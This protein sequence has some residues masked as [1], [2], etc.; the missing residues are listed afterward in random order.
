MS[1]ITPEYLLQFREYNLDV[2]NE[3]EKYIDNN[4]KI[5]DL[6]IFWKRDFK[7]K[8]SWFKTKE[9]MTDDEKI[10]TETNDLLN[11]LN[12]SNFDSISD[13]VLKL[14]L[15]CR[16][17]MDKLVI[18]VIDGAIANNLYIDVFAKLCHK[19]SQFYII[20]NGEKVHFR[21]ILKTKVQDKFEKY[22][23][24]DMTIDKNN[25]FGICK[26]IG[27]LYINGMLT[28]CIVEMC[29]INLYPGAI[30][31]ITNM[32]EAMCILMEIIGKYFYKKDAS[33]ADIFFTRIEKILNSGNISAKEKFVIQDLLELHKK[34]NWTNINNINDINDI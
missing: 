29:F 12:K 22:T 26:L 27:Y 31:R 6:S 16:N 23:K 3:L 30:N 11:K 34:E 2:P 19:L 9:S 18:R 32:V 25:L 8:V 20:E 28:N 13:S 10:F 7:P 21:D 5:K 24:N 15:T 1:H 4:K 33:K 17:H 14:Q